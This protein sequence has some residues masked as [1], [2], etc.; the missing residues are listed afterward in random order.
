MKKMEANNVIM[1]YNTRLQNDR[2]YE[3]INT[4]RLARQKY[5]NAT[6]FITKIPNHLHPSPY[7]T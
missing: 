1:S 4:Q 6:L 2:L 5:N 3:S 7:M